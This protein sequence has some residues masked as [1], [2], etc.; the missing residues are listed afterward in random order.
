MIHVK[1]STEPSQTQQIQ[2]ISTEYIKCTNPST[3]SYLKHL[4]NQNFEVLKNV[5]L[6]LQKKCKQRGRPSKKRAALSFASASSST[7]KK[8]KYFIYTYM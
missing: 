3:F 8:S 7:V 2:K 4:P 6:Q 5:H 1:R